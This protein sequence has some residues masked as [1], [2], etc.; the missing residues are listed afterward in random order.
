M[1]ETIIFLAFGFGDLTI[2]VQ[3]HELS[4]HTIAIFR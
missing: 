1:P 3:A 2:A 4:L